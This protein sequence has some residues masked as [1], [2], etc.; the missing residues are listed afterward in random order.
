MTVTGVSL[1]AYGMKKYG[2]RRISLVI[3]AGTIT[4]LSLLFL[5]FSMNAVDADFVTVVTTWWPVLLIVLGILLI[6]LHVWRIR[7][8]R[9]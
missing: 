5:P 4:I 8:T 2:H 1:Y 9:R 3:P 7:R 6:A